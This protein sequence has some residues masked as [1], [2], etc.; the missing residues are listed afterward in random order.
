MPRYFF[1]IEGPNNFI[2]DDR[3][4]TILP[5]IVSAR[6]YAE[7]TIRKLRTE[8]GY[9]DPL[10]IMMVKDDRDQTIL[11]LPFLPACA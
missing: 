6:S 11:S 5:D 7:R 3:H 10:L 2:S 9:D 8:R 1:T 4:G